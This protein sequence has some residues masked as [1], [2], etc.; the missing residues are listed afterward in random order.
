MEVTRVRLFAD[1]VRPPTLIPLLLLAAACS[2]SGDRHPEIADAVT[3]DSCIIETRTIWQSAANDDHIVDAEAYIEVGDTL[4]MMGGHFE[5]GI[6]R[7]SLR[8]GKSW[9]TERKGEGPGEFRWIVVGQV[10][11]QDTLVVLEDRRTS[12]VTRDLQFVRSYPNQFPMPVGLWVL[13]DGTSIIPNYNA[14]SPA[15]AIGKALHRVSAEGQYLGSFRATNSPADLGVWPMAPGN[16]SGTL[17][18]VESK[19]T[20]F[21]AELW[22]VPREQRLRVITEAPS[23]WVGVSKSPPDHEKLGNKSTLPKL[24][25][26][27]VGVWQAEQVLWVALRQ[28]DAD[29]AHASLGDGAR[30]RWFDGVLLAIDLNNGSILA[31]TVFDE[32]L[33]GF[34]NRGRLVLTDQ[35][36]GGQPRVRLVEVKLR[37]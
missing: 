33:A 7:V 30:H 15:G 11:A 8:G 9:V 32:F 24:P 34:T 20:G 14:R 27:A 10:Y 16:E 4:W 13:P 28:F 35:D 17:W 6:G 37:R 31:A 19:V 23:W 2:S 26:G 36:R 29:Y 1:H 5:A 3:C 18:V 21:V 12:V 22:D 25:S